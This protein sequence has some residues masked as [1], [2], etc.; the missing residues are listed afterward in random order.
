[1]SRVVFYPRTNKPAPRPQ[2]KM[3][4]QT[5]V[6][7]YG[8]QAWRVTDLTPDRIYWDQLE[9]R[10]EGKYFLSLAMD[11]ITDRIDRFMPEQGNILELMCGRHSLFTKKFGHWV[12]GVSLVKRSM[13]LNMVLD[14]F[15]VRDLN[16]QPHL[17]HEATFQAAV[18]TFGLTYLTRPVEVL[19]A[20]RQLLT[21]DARL[22]IV[23]ANNCYQPE[24][25]PAI[26]NNVREQDAKIT[27]FRNQIELTKDLMIRSGFRIIHAGE[28]SEL[29]HLSY[30]SFMVVGERI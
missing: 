29:Y 1:M 13:T 17:A 4:R 3:A 18:M 30:D 28:I 12:H 14:S 6:S 22:I 19:Q 7:A 27:A 23:C 24:K 20:V 25:A 21:P 9:T 26:W 8:Q 5:S 16:E 15:D 2:P 10:L 11:W